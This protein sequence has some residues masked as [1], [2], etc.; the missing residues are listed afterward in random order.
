MKIAFA[1]AFLLCLCAGPVLAGDF[2]LPPATLPN[3]AGP[4]LRQWGDD[5]GG[6]DYSRD[7]F[8]GYRQKKFSMGIRGGIYL[9]NFWDADWDDYFGTTDGDDGFLLSF[10]GEVFG[11]YQAHKYIRVQ[12]G[13]GISRRGTFVEMS[14]SGPGFS[15]EMEQDWTLDYF[16]IPVALI[17]TYP[18]GTVVTPKAYGGLNFA[19]H[20]E[21]RMRGW[22]EV[23][24]LGTTNEDEQLREYKPDDIQ[25][26]DFGIFFGIGA[27]FEISPGAY[28]FLDARYTFSVT[29][30]SDDDTFWGNDLEDSKHEYF[31]F[32][33]GFGY[34]V[35]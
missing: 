11:A 22:S 17:G 14:S 20:I 31:A 27:D 1:T 3:P 18:T 33:A 9:V 28:V 2:A 6:D 15:M 4:L 26:F 19:I 34:A 29:K 10:G 25:N 21:G 32:T 8:S 30:F 12:M 13:L 24:V 5:F 23:T 16:D 35:G 7:T